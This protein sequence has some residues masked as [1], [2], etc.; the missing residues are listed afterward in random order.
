LAQEK[1]VILHKDVPVEVLGYQLLYKGMTENSYAQI[2]V[3]SD[4]TVYTAKPRFYYSAYN[5]GNMREPDIRPGILSDFYISPLEHRSEEE[6]RISLVKGET[7]YYA[8]YDI[9]FTEFQME[10]HTE[11]GHFVV[12]ARLSFKGKDSTFIVMPAIIMASEGRQMQPAQLPGSGPD[13]PPVVTLTELNADDKQIELTFSGLGKASDQHMHE[14]LVVEVST[15]PMMSILWM[16]T[17]LIIGGIVIAFNRR[18][19]GT[20]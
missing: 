17:V 5:R 3:V 9:T 7:K 10:N 1:Q 6:N 2:E 20:A 13:G 18:L 15:K 12:G 19:S 14:Q 8:G 4:Q 11:G 16:G